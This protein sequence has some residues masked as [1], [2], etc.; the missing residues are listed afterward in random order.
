[1]K[2]TKKRPVN[3]VKQEFDY[4]APSSRAELLHCLDKKGRPI[5]I[6]CIDPDLSK[7]SS[8]LKRGCSLKVLASRG[9]LKD[10]GGLVVVTHILDILPSL[11]S[12]WIEQL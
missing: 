1:M 12:N 6:N 9:K 4:V 3:S 5:L 10:Y 8:A 7:M 2:R 11:Q